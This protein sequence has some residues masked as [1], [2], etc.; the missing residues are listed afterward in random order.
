MQRWGE[1]EGKVVHIGEEKQ[2]A[3]SIGHRAACVLGV[4][5]GSKFILKSPIGDVP[6]EVEVGFRGK[7]VKA[8]EVSFYKIFL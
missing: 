1:R 4:S 5:I 6:S 2:G 8:R 7:R 3:E